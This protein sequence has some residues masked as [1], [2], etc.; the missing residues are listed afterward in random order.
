MRKVWLAL[1][2]VGIVF[3]G[4]CVAPGDTPAPQ[5]AEERFIEVVE[6]EF[7]PADAQQEQNLIDFGKAVCNE[8]PDWSAIMMTGLDSEMDNEAFGFLVGVSIPAFCPEYS[9]SMIDWLESQMS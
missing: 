1:M 2:A 9:E 4:G 8:A 7:G 3:L 6:E 5:T